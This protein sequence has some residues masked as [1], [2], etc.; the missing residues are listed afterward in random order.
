M[1]NDRGMIKWVPFNSVVNSQKIV[2]EIL[3]ERQKIVLPEISL[4]DEENIEKNIINAY[5]TKSITN[6]VYYENGYLYKITSKIKKI[7][8]VYK[9]I[10]LDNKR[11]LFKQIN[12]IN[13]F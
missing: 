13:Y 11:L 1:N 4:E 10:Y 5:Y 12:K 6:I 8:Q 2:K 3:K 9:M 7:D